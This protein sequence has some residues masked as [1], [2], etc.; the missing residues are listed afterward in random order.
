MLVGAFKTYKEGKLHVHMNMYMHVHFDKTKKDQMCIYDCTCIFNI[1]KANWFVITY[2][3]CVWFEIHFRPVCLSKR[4]GSILYSKSELEKNCTNAV[5]VLNLNF[6]YKFN[7]HFKFQSF[8]ELMFFWIYFDIFTQ[9]IR[10]IVQINQLNY[11]LN[12]ICCQKQHIINVVVFCCRNIS[13]RLN[14]YF[15]IEIH[16]MFEME[17]R[18]GIPNK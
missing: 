18:L 12:D 6:T 2:K 17:L 14:E 16:E 9:A 8:Y 7:L 13:Q 3:G 5:V 10:A 15:I 4:V 11:S 1:L